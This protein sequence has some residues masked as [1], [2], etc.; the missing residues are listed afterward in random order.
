M[1][2]SIAEDGRKHKTAGGLARVER[3]I[4]LEVGKHYAASNRNVIF[5]LFFENTAKALAHLQYKFDPLPLS[6][7]LSPDTPSHILNEY[8]D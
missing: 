1:E 7:R 8:R 2:L 3:H 5:P 4:Q 6:I